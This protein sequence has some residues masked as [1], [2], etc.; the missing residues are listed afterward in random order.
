VRPTFRNLTG[1]YET[2][3]FRRGL[4]HR[5]WALE[6]QHLLERDP[7]RRD[8]RIYR[9]TKQGRLRALGGR[10]P[11]ERWSRNWDGRWR[12]VVFDVPATQNSR[13][14][15]LRRYL[16][17]RGFGCLQNS[18]WITPDALE[19]EMKILSGGKANVKSMILLDVRP[20]AGESDSEIVASAWN[21]KRINSLYKQHLRVLDDRPT[22]ALRNLEA[23]RALQDWATREQN[24][25]RSAVQIDPLL[26]ESI[27]PAVYL[28]KKAWK[29]RM[30]ALLEAGGQLQ[31]F[32]P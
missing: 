5:V 7:A 3:A 18:V 32:N 1:S 26:P 6:R 24:A 29:K 27:L 14:T 17:K 19:E 30:E 12:L 25:W 21:F 23:A 4:L 10:D 16:R 22:E 11:Q 31:T 15:R 20:C 28:G 2:W 8:E 9:L 13:R